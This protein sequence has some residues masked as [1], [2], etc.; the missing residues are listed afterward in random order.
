M[1]TEVL[2]G[3]LELEWEI[4]PRL[5]G[6]N[7]REWMLGGAAVA[8]KDGVVH[9][10]RCDN[11]TVK[12]FGSIG[13]RVLEGVTSALESTDSTYSSMVPYSNNI[14]ILCQSDMDLQKI[15]NST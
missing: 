4:P 3:D 10:G 2:T 7:I 8:L 9:I 6:Q 13:S 12:F 15:Q 11:E 1:A 14:P 5:I